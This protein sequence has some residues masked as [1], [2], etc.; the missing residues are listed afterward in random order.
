MN[1]RNKTRLAAAVSSGILM[2]LLLLNAEAFATEV[3]ALPE[4]ECH[5]KVLVDYEKPLREMRPIHR[6]P[7]T[8]DPS[9]PS[10]LAFG[11]GRLRMSVV[12]DSALAG[13]RDVGFQLSAVPKKGLGPVELDWRVVSQLAA[14]RRSGTVAKELFFM[15]TNIGRL[16]ADGS[17]RLEL[18]LTTP[19]QAGFYR[20]QSTFFDASGKHLGRYAEYFRILRWRGEFG[21]SVSPRHLHGGD[22]LTSRVETSGTLPILFG[23][24][25]AID[26]FEGGEWQL[27][28]MTPTDFT[29]E[30]Y[31]MYP[32]LLT[33]CRLLR[34]PVDASPGHYRLRR[35]LGAFGKRDQLMMADFHVL[36]K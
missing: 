31:L 22:V 15:R 29:G 6:L 27:D 24:F 28:P 30:L 34:L 33:E 4:S 8:S 25:F 2:S 35:G 23:N 5:T 11:P 21:A 36:L 3:E 17:E 32:G 14:V 7:G 13:P 10:R 12:G 19:R 18:T 9:V 16:R 20:I 1:L 26:R